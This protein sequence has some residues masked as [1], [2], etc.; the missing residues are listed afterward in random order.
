MEFDG[1]NV[2]EERKS[3]AIFETALACVLFILF[4]FIFSMGYSLI[5]ARFRANIVVECVAQFLVEFLFAVAAYVV[6]RFRHIDCLAAAGMKKK[7]SGKIVG[8]AFLISAVLL[9]FFSSLTDVFVSLLELIGYSSSS[10]D[11]TVNNFWVYLAYTF[12][13]CVAPALFEELLFRGVILSGLRNFGQKIAI[14]IS[15]LIFMLMHGS[16]DQTIHQFIIGLV[17]GYIFYK[18]SNLWIG[19][20][21]HFFNNF[22]AITLSFIYSLA[23]KQIDSLMET[24]TQDAATLSTWLN[25][26]IS[27]A[28]A[29][30]SAV[31]GW[32]ILKGIFKKLFAEDAKINGAQAEGQESILDERTVVVSI[33][34][35]VVET[36]VA[37]QG[38]PVQDNAFIKENFKEAKK[39]QEEKV[40]ISCIVMFALSGLYLVL[41]WILALASGF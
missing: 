24:A 23:K 11:I 2:R 22:I 16:P 8:L 15:A 1:L 28:I 35:K 3:F 33:D 30:V 36:T 6:S 9:L 13:I 10:S 4:N 38:E 19:I 34:G 29:V 7:I 5:P 18:T 26:L 20:I 27:L 41:E 25:I 17:T 14:I 12:V 39:R 37:I 40:P 31:V 21:V 32:Y